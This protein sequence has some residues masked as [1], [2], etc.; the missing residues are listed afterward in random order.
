[1]D[2]NRSEPF[3]S[4]L[5]HAEFTEEGIPVLYIDNV[6]SN[7]FPWAKP[8]YITP[9]KYTSFLR[10]RVF[11]GDVIVTIM[12]TT[13][14]VCAMPDD[15]PECM[16]TK[17]LCVFTLDRVR[18]DPFIVGGRFCSTKVF[19]G[20]L[21]YKLKGR[22]WKDGIYLSSNA[23]SYAFRRSVAKGHSRGSWPER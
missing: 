11:P 18:A 10:C 7:K 16:S 8:R 4:Q 17:R 12:G 23:S 6:V 15:L 2:A 3:G 22:S 21:A 5:K 9:E 14:R 19:A 20:K 13:G 1:M